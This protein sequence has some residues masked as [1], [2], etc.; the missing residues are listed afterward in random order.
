MDNRSTKYQL[1][2]IDLLKIGRIFLV[3]IGG[4]VLTELAQLLPSVNF[5]AYTLVVIPIA[6]ALVEAGRRWL[7]D[8]SK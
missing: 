5:G 4:V 2:K 8:Y 3:A 6:M 7:T 1:N